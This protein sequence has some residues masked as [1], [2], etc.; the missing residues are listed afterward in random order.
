LELKILRPPNFSIKQIG[1]VMATTPKKS[2]IDTPAEPA[3]AIDAEAPAPA[4]ETTPVY[5]PDNLGDVVGRLR[6][7]ASEI[8]ATAVDLAAHHSSDH[9]VAGR[10]HALR[11][12]LSEFNQAMSNFK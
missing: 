1:A 8:K 4:I 6:S 3:P 9:A 11:L 7:L 10:V 12:A 5:N 2:A